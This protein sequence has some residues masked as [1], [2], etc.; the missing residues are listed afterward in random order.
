M[1][2]LKIGLPKTHIELDRRD[3][4]LLHVV[5]LRAVEYIDSASKGHSDGR[6]ALETALEQ[7]E[8]EMGSPEEFE[9]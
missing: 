3:R 5:W 8:D 4:K 2:R 6:A 9:V 7:A 1:G